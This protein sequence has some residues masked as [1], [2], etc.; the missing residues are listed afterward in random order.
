MHGWRHGIGGKQTMKVRSGF[1][2]VEMLVVI[3]IIGILIVALVPMVRSAQERAKEAAVKTQCASIETALA[4]YAQN[5]GG[6]YPG[7]AIDVMAPFADH[8]LGDPDMYASGGTG[9]LAPVE[10]QLVNGVLG[11]YGHYNGSTANVFE[12]LKNVKDTPLPGGPSDIARYFDTLIASDAIQ[13]YPPNP[14]ISTAT[15]ER[16]RMRNVFV[17]TIFLGSGFD[18]TVPG[19]GFGSTSTYDCRLYTARGG[20]VNPPGSYSMDANDTMRGF[21]EQLPMGV[22]LSNWDPATFSLDCAFGTDENDYFSPGDFAYV[23]LLS[24]S[25]HPFGDSMATVENEIYKWGTNVTGY[26]LFGYG[27]RS[28]QNRE[29]EDAQREFVDNGLPGMG[30]IGVDTI[31]ENYVLQLFEGAIF[32]SKHF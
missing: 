6:N 27:S 17:F 21:L 19:N 28:H 2:L 25:A 10:R 31:Y 7:V 18:P 13:E 15:G 16:A 24:S 30:G 14:F 11:G 23:P 26:M 4:T 20:T 5:H 3:G 22:P 29:Y 32:F 9:S 1:T 8:A 12:Q